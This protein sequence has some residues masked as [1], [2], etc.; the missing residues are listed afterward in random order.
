MREDWGTR[1]TSLA[2]RTK[3]A[4]EWEEHAPIKRSTERISNMHW[5]TFRV[6]GTV[7]RICGP[8]PYVT[9]FRST[10]LSTLALAEALRA[11]LVTCDRAL[12]SAP[13]H[14]AKVVVIQFSCLDTHPDSGHPYI[15]IAGWIT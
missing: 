4:A 10:M 15:R 7:Y 6:Y 11:P 8:L 1:P 14:R 2:E 12:A 5:H 13:G 3:T 9:T